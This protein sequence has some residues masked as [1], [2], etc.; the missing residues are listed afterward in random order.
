MENSL[1]IFN[2]PEFGQIRSVFAS[3]NS[4]YI[5]FSLYVNLFPKKLLL[6]F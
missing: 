4:C 3:S 5:Y 1:Q 2:N 6:P